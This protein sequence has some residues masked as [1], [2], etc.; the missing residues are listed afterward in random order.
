MG[1]VVAPLLQLVPGLA[2]RNALCT[3]LVVS[4]SGSPHQ[5]TALCPR[6]AYPVGT[7][8]TQCSPERHSF[9]STSLLLPCDACAPD[10]PTLQCQTHARM[11]AVC[12]AVSIRISPA[13]CSRAR[14]VRTSFLSAAASRTAAPKM[15]DTFCEGARTCSSSARTN[16][17]G[18]IVIT[19]RLPSRQQ[20]DGRSVAE[21]TAA[22]FSSAT[23]QQ[24]HDDVQRATESF[25]ESLDTHAASATE[26]EPV[27]PPLENSDELA[28]R[29]V[30]REDCE[31]DDEDEDCWIIEPEAAKVVGKDAILDEVSSAAVQLA[32]SVAAKLGD[33]DEA[34]AGI[35][36]SV[37]NGVRE[38]GE[39]VDVERVSKLVT[40]AF[41]SA[42]LHKLVALALA[43]AHIA[44]FAHTSEPVSAP[45]L[46]NPLSFVTD[47][48]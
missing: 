24:P 26:R 46:P 7:Y 44:Y 34:T 39:E 29:Y 1:V 13:S 45:P 4:D 38:E 40:R 35:V 2:L 27:T 47:L 14:A 25:A 42:V 17:T 30:R 10:I 37:L 8:M 15:H 22:R 23:R 28:P 3:R 20:R 19:V 32:G 41:V 12:P 18:I 36:S 48:L 21:Q 16:G 6:T 11:P 31:E 9:T 5:L 43:A 33:A